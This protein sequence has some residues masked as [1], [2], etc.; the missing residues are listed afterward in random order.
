MSLLGQ[1]RTTAQMASGVF[2]KGPCCE[3]ER[4]ALYAHVPK[5]SRILQQAN[6]AR[7]NG[8]PTRTQKAD[9]FSALLVNNF[10]EW[11][12]RGTNITTITQNNWIPYL[13]G[14]FTET[15]RLQENLTDAS[16]VHW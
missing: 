3:N 14:N 15:R 10:E 12:T 9:G 2:A 4:D 5:D 1:D 13:N 8:L 16:S 6:A 11:R 7:V